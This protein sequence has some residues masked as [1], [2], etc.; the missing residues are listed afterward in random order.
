MGTTSVLSMKGA[1]RIAPKPTSASSR[2]AP[3]KMA[4][5]GIEVSGRVVPMA[6]STLPTAPSE[7]F[8]RRPNHSIAFVNSAQAPRVTTTDTTNKSP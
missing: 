7:S 8:R 2:L 5:I 4:T 1:P 3:K 6:A